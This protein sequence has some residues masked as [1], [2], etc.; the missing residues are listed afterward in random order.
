[1][2]DDIELFGR[3][4]MEKSFEKPNK[5]PKADNDEV[6]RERDREGMVPFMFLSL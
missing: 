4:A 6:E 3:R 5:S 1:M 2:A